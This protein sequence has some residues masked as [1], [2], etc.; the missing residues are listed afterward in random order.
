MFVSTANSVNNKFLDTENIAASNSLPA[1]APISDTVTS[2]T[3]S[4]QN[5]TPTGT[6]EIRVNDT[7]IANPPAASVSLGGTQTQVFSVS[8]TV[9]QADL[10]NCYIPGASGVQKPLIKLYI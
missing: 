9:T 4:N 2:L 6:I 1:V 3:F 10:I 7:N 5:A 8:F